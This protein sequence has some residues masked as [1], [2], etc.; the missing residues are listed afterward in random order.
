MIQK[1]IINNRI[2]ELRSRYSANLEE[3]RAKLAKLLAAEE[4][5]Y[6]QEFNDK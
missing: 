1:G 4:R 2:A 5:Q 3:R 6:E